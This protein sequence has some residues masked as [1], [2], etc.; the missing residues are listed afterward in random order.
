MSWSRLDAELDRWTAA[1][2]RATL[3][4]R[5]DD[6]C[7]S[8][9]ALS[10]LLSICEASGVPVALAAIPALI[11][12]TLVDAV[13][14][15]STCTL[16]QHGFAHRNH[17]PTGE[18]GSELGEHRPVDDCL[19][20]LA[21]GLERMRVA[22]GGRF[23]PV[24]VPPWNRIAP[25][26]VLRL[27]GIGL[28]GLSTFGPRSTAAA[29]PG[30]TRCNAHVDLIAW[31]RGRQF[32]GDEAAVLRLVAHLEARREHVA[33]EAEPTGILTHHLDLDAAAWRFL[34]ELFDRTRRHAAADWVDAA[35]AFGLTV[36]VPA[37]SARSA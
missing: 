34:D 28:R 32:I 10:R 5:D 17:A 30:L 21:D 29:A 31:R 35:T 13:A 1:G 24:L 19:A 7:R 37:T 8:T 11:D 26:V 6:A 14:A 25:A 3:W 27:A 16:L 23:V 22:G 2:R 9:P 15:A 36:P 12:R 33:D 20:E 4:L 18:R